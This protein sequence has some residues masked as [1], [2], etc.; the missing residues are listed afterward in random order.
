MEAQSSDYK[1]GWVGGLRDALMRFAKGPRDVGID[2]VLAKAKE[3][4]IILNSCTDK[5]I[6][7][8]TKIYREAIGFAVQAVANESKPITEFAAGGPADMNRFKRESDIYPTLA[9]QAK[10]TPPSVTPTNTDSIFKKELSAEQFDTL[11]H[12]VGFKIWVCAFGVWKFGVKEIG[13]DVAYYLDGARVTRE[14]LR[15]RVVAPT[16]AH[17]ALEWVKM[18]HLYDE[19]QLKAQQSPKYTVA[20]ANPEAASMETLDQQSREFMNT[21]ADEI[22]AKSIKSIVRS[23]FDKSCEQLAAGPGRGDHATDYHM[24][25]AIL[26][27]VSDQPSHPP[28]NHVLIHHRDKDSNRLIAWRNSCD[29]RY[30]W[31]LDTDA[32][33]DYVRKATEPV[34]NEYGRHLLLN[35]QAWPQN[36][37]MGCFEELHDVAYGLMIDHLANANAAADERFMK[38]VQSGGLQHERFGRL[39]CA[40]N[41]ASPST[42]CPVCGDETTHVPNGMNCRGKPPT[43]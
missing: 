30:V 8:L 13:V 28:I 37:P 23:A 3:C 41:S 4:S 16:S 11:D 33:F 12:C 39:M 25:H 10:P 21:I 26:N 27:R 42:S 15:A 31:W 19:Q 20:T 5:D 35:A 2:H 40:D 24:L 32:T 38:L 22:I 18:K 17:R 14:E 34:Q 1:V 36:I 7:W 9:A 6:E 43:A 29:D